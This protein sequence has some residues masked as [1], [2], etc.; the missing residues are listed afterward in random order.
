MFYIAC[1]FEAQYVREKGRT[2]TSALAEAEKRAVSEGL[3]DF[4]DS[5]Q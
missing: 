1:M 2:E 3:D 5:K 4:A